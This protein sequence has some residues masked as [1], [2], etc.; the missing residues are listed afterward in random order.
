MFVQKENL[1]AGKSETDRGRQKINREIERYIER[2]RD[3]ECKIRKKGVKEVKKN[4]VKRVKLEQRELTCRGARV[5]CCF[6]YIAFCH[7]GSQFYSL[8]PVLLQ[9]LYL[10]HSGKAHI[11][12]KKKKRV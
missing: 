1:T 8:F 3:R 4:P 7:F 12:R 5:C 11:K 2:K 6:I 10:P 9:F